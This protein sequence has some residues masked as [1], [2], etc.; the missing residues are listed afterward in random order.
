LIRDGTKVVAL[1]VIDSPKLT[2]S[3]VEGFAQQRNVLDAVLRT[4]PLKRR[5]L[6]NYI[7]IRN[8]VF[9]PRTP[10][11]CS[12]GLVKHLLIHDLKNLTGNKEVADTIR[13]LALRTYKQKMEKRTAQR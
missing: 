6:K 7:V 10:I 4:I 12:L 11:D 3:E 9:N 13:K 2:D 1:A 8:L 5:Y